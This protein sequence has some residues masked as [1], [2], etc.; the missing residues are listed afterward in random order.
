[1]SAF[2]ELFQLQEMDKELDLIR[3]E[4]NRLPESL[5]AVRTA[6]SALL[7]QL[8]RLEEL[9]LDLQRRYREGDL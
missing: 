2:A 9:I 7:E 4:Q 3:D 6:R 1:V 8:A 5:I